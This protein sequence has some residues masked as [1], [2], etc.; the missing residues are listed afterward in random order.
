MWNGALARYRL[1][2]TRTNRAII[3][4]SPIEPATDARPKQQTPP[5]RLSTIE[6][7]LREPKSKNYV[8]RPTYGSPAAPTSR[9]ARPAS[10]RPEITV[11]DIST[12]VLV[13]QLGAVDVSRLG[14][15]AGHLTAAEQWAIDTALLTV[16]GLT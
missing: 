9:S 10:F 8:S 6:Q 4:T 12:R 3:R 7:E 2:R 5:M 13:E 1:R 14:D 11:G 15:P 16:L